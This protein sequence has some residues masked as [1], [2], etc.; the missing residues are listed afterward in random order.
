MSREQGRGIPPVSAD[1][2]DGFT[3]DDLGSGPS[4]Q[5]SDTTQ[6]STSTNTRGSQYHSRLTSSR[7]NCHIYMKKDFDPS[8]PPPSV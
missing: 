2:T 6:Y 4:L 1:R 3:M 7:A 8:D 5:D